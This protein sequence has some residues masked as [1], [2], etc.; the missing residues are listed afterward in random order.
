MKTNWKTE[1]DLIHFFREETNQCLHT[2]SI[3]QVGNGC[4]D[5]I[6]ASRAT[7]PF[8]AEFKL[9]KNAESSIP[10][11]RMQL[12]WSHDFTKAGGK[13]VCIV[14]LSESSEIAVFNMSNA[15]EK[16]S[17]IETAEYILQ[18]NKMSKLFMAHLTIFSQLFKL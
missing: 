2:F 10:W 1:K 12:P 4:P 16:L 3:E 11:R 5:Y 13:A 14:G 6:M 8:L 18:N 15:A 17:Q 7:G 9:V